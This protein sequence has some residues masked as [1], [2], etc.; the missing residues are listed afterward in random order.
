MTLRSFLL[1]LSLAIAPCVQ[2]ID[3]TQAT[4]VYNPKDA[5]LVKQMALMLADDIERVSGVKPAVA[6]RRAAG[7]NILLAT[8]RYAAR[9]PKA[10]RGAWERFA[11][12]TR[13]ND[14]YITGSDARGLAYGV[15]HVS[16][17]IG[18]SPW[19]WFADVPVLEAVIPVGNYVEQYV[20]NEP[21][22]RYRGIFINDEDWGLKTWAAC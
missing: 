3:L 16:E 14:L 15:L 12:E 13:G 4:I 5:P 2:A 11:I 18:V 6:T 7:E 1:L 21:T 8:S 10:L 9:S 19:Y 22:I 17:Q 20:S